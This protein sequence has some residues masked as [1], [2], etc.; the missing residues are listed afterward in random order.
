MRWLDFAS[1]KHIDAYDLSPQRIEYAK[2]QAIE[3]GVGETVNYQ[4]AD[5]ARLNLPT[6]HYDL[7]LAE[8]SLHH[9]S[10]LEQILRN[11]STT[12]KPNGI[13]VINEFVGPTRFQWTD[14][15]LDAVN[16]LL[17]LLPEKYKILYGTQTIKKKVQRPSLF[18]MW[19][20]DP[21]EAVESSRILPLLNEL[22]DV[23]EARNYGG[24]I[25]H[26]LFDQIAYNFL[27]DSAETKRLL[28]LCFEVEDMLIENNEVSTDFA[29][30]VCKN[31]STRLTNQ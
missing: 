5:I 26:L 18:S 7:I 16:S 27:S 15:Q 20:S 19:L 13:F 22:F 21:S 3:K 8:M 1:F 28:S 4:T 25:L 9:F 6:N 17:A 24:T 11:V 14:R 2:N 12:L 29:F 30:I 31:I 23:V 10:P